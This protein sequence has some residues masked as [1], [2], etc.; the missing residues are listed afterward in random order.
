MFSALVVF[1]PRLSL[2][3]S[4]AIAHPRISSMTADS[5]IGH[6]KQTL[7]RDSSIEL[8]MEANHTFLTRIWSKACPKRPRTSSKYVRSCFS[9]RSDHARRYAN[10]GGCCYPKKSEYLRPRRLSVTFVQQDFGLQ[11]LWL[12][13]LHR[14]IPMHLLIGVNRGQIA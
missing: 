14:A 10:F 6:V 7:A 2:H 12:Y 5:R 13:H 3:S 1:F 4:S 11:Q 8:M 9:S